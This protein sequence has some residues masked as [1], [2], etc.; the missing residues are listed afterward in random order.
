MRTFNIV[1]VWLAVSLVGCGS[2]NRQIEVGDGEAIDHDLSTVNGSITVGVG[3]T[4]DGNLQTVN[5]SI[6]LGRDSRAVHLSTVNGS[7]RLAEG[8]RA[9]SA[10]SAQEARI[11]GSATT[12]NGGFKAGN[13][14]RVDGSVQTANG[15]IH[16]DGAEAGSLSNVNGGMLLENDCKVHGELVVKRPQRTGGDPPRIEILSGCRVT[17][18]L[19]FERQVLLRVDESARIGEIQGTEP[20]RVSD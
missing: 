19:R 13:G 3:S 14:A 20:I 4:I 18:P 11:E 10:E 5:G 1:A 9:R 2:V 15:Q 7:V 8:A 16:L 17:G 12:V 6:R